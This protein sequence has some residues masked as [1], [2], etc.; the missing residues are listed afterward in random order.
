MQWM[1]SAVL[2]LTQ[3]ADHPIDHTL[4]RDGRAE[5]RPMSLTGNRLEFHEGAR[6]SARSTIVDSQEQFGVAERAKAHHNGNGRL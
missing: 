5:A 4:M 3:N 1:K 2:S 6:P